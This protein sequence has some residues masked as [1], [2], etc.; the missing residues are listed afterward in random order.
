MLLPY[1]VYDNLQWLWPQLWEHN[2]MGNILW[3]TLVESC[4]NSFKMHLV[5]GFTRSSMEM[6]RWRRETLAS[7]RDRERIFQ[8]CDNWKI[9]SFAKPQKPEEN[10]NASLMKLL[11]PTL[12]R[13]SKRF[14][15]PKSYAVKRNAERGRSCFQKRKNAQIVLILGG[16]TL[17]LGVF[18]WF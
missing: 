7:S 14:K 6:N 15:S 12:C 2:W 5:D 18:G 13:F 10:A 17:I 4:R 16:F 9:S 3:K 11:L 1:M 8:S